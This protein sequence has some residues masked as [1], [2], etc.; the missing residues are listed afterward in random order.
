MLPTISQ[1]RYSSTKTRLVAARRA[2]AEAAATALDNG[3]LGNGD[4]VDG[5]GVEL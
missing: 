1:P 4:D 3:V 2:V 5:D